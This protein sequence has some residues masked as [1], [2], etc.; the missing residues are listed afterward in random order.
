[1]D[2]KYTTAIIIILF[3]IIIILQVK[4]TWMIYD[5]SEQLDSDPLV[6]GAQR[7]GIN[8]CE[9]KVSQ[10]KQIIF[11][12]TSSSTKIIKNAPQIDYNVT[13][14]YFNNS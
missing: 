12:Q 2:K 7:Y 11:N 3:I 6:L 14:G 8:Y 9:C 1:M 5:R 13:I 10:T 4:V